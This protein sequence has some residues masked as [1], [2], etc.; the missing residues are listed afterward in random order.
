MNRSLCIRC[1]HIRI[2]Q[3]NRDWDGFL[4]SSPPDLKLAGD[5]TGPDH[6]SEPLGLP[7]SQSPYGPAKMIRS[8]GISVIPLPVR[9]DQ[10]GFPGV[11]S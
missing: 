3:G 1:L 10:F 9:T 8:R 5:E 7:A 11:T 6:I 4:L 2:G